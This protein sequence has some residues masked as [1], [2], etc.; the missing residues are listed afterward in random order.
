MIATA[1]RAVTTPNRL[2]LFAKQTKKYARG[3]GKWKAYM[4]TDIFIKK[5]TKTIMK[6]CKIK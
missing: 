3:Q 5:P 6:S 4:C 2:L 1:R